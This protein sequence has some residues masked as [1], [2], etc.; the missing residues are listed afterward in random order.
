MAQLIAVFLGTTA[1]VGGVLVIVVSWHRIVTDD[2]RLLNLLAQVCDPA[3]PVEDVLDP[4]AALFG[5]EVTCTQ[6]SIY[7][8]IYK[9]SDRDGASIAMA[10]PLP[11][12][13]H[14]PAEIVTTPLEHDH[15]AALDQ[16]G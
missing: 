16:K 8:S 7:G 3:A 15:H 5:T 13:R 1:W 14:R 2:P 12:E 4:V 11:G 10:A 6:R 9:V